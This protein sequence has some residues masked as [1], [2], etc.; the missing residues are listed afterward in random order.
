MTTLD[1]AQPR[2]RSTIARTAAAVERARELLRAMRA[3]RDAR[4]AARH[5]HTLNDDMLRDIGMDR[6]Q[7]ERLVRGGSTPRIRRGHADD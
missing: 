7:I 3:W 4:T 1:Y 5:L 6:G 2:R